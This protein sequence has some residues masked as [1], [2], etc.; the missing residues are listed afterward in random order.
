MRVNW[1]ITFLVLAPLLLSAILIKVKATGDRDYVPW[2][3]VVLPKPSA[4]GEAA[5]AFAFAPDSQKIAVSTFQSGVQIWDIKQSKFEKDFVRFHNGFAGEATDVSWGDHDFVV[6]GETFYHIFDVASRKLKFE[7][8]THKQAALSHFKIGEHNQILIS[9]DATL[10]VFAQVD[11]RV[12]I[13][14]LQMDTL[15]CSFKTPYSQTC[16]LALSKDKQVLAVGIALFERKSADPYSIPAAGF[17]IHLHD[18]RTGK[19]LKV[20]PYT[21]ASISATR[22]EYGGTLRKMSMAFSPDGKTLVSGS[23]SGG[24]V[25]D[26]AS[27]QVVHQLGGWNPMEDTTK[28]AF[29]PDGSLIAVA[30]GQNINIW[31]AQKGEALQVFHDKLHWRSLTFSPDSKHLASGGQD[32]TGNGV[33]Q[34]WDV[35]DLK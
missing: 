7:F 25:W 4:M 31:S 22:K 24:R 6:S 11:G 8:P 26:V 3:N 16:G 27:G 23:D 20:I 34:I 14:N 9:P 18:A 15:N 35:S 1:K 10:A 33:F 29:S 12:S 5:H 21:D 28:I 30:S 13:W 17:E 19:L 2:Q 32:G